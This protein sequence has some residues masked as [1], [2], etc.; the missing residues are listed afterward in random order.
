MER[1]NSLQSRKDSGW[2][3][4]LSVLGRICILRMGTT[5]LRRP[6]E[7]TPWKTQHVIPLQAFRFQ[8]GNTSV[9]GGQRKV[10]NT[11]GLSLLFSCDQLASEQHTWGPVR[12]CSKQNKSFAPHPCGVPTFQSVYHPC[13]AGKT[14]LG[15]LYACR[16]LQ[17]ILGNRA[18]EEQRELNW[19]LLV[20]LMQ[21]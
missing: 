1:L 18:G 5:C 15:P 3:C 16:L 7:L 13:T 20:R 17:R 8:A 19:Y 10:V 14:A 6:R 11:R 2:I 9:Q 4:V 12:L 21:A